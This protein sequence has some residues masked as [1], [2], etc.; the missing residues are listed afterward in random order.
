MSSCNDDQ[1]KTYSKH[2]FIFFP[3]ESSV[4]EAVN[5]QREVT[6]KET[7]WESY[8][9]DTITGN[10]VKSSNYILFLTTSNTD[11]VPEHISAS[12]YN[13]V[14]TPKYE[15]LQHLDDALTDSPNLNIERQIKESYNKAY[16]VESEWAPPP[17]RKDYR[18]TEVKSIDI[19]ST[20]TV[21]G[22]KAGTSL[23]H[24]FLITH[25]S[26]IFSAPDQMVFGFESEADADLSIDKYLS[27]HP[28]AH[29]GLYLYLTS[30]PTEAPLETRFIVE[31]EMEGGTILRDTTD[32]V[33]LLP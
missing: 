33:N 18:L 5:A 14:K 21:F 17:V 28:L 6:D 16:K 24:F 13:P 15:L 3:R 32:V 31:M 11:V 4:I 12:G 2:S 27:Y 19:R 20:E 10:S 9:H 8:R 26:Y 25:P 30:T 22:N 23:N 7:Q 1:S 29:A